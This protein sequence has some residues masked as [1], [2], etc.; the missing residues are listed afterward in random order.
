LPWRAF[1]NSA[2]RLRSC[3][4]RAVGGAMVVGFGVFAVEGKEEG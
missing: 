2:S 1:L 4:S 3:A